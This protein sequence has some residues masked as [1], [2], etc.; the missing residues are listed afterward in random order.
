MMGWFKQLIKKFRQGAEQ[1]AISFVH[2][3]KTA[4]TSF[5]VLLDRFFQAEA[6]FPHQLWR[7]VKQLSPVKN[8]RYELFRGHFGGGG[9]KH[10]TTRPL[11]YLTILRDPVSLACSTYQYV[12]REQN[13]RVHDLLKADEMSLAVFINH[14]ETGPLVTNRLIRNISFDFIDDPAAQEVFLSPQTI[15]YLQQHIKPKPQPL[16]D[17]DRLIRAETFLRQ[18]RWFG[19]VERFDESM[20][21]LCFTMGWRPIGQSQRLNTSRGIELSEQTEQALK[22]LNLEDLRLYQSAKVMFSERHQQMLTQLE[23]LRTGADQTVD[24]LLDVHYQQQPH[25]MASEVDH[26]FDQ[27]VQG[28]QW[29]RREWLDDEQGYFRWTGPGAQANIDFWLQPQDYQLR[30]RIINA[31]STELLDE[32]QLLVN[33]QL[34]NWH[35]EDQGVVR[36][37]TAQCPA[38]WVAPNGLFRLSL[39]V[40]DMI[41]HRDAF[42]SDD[43][44]LVGV[45]VHWIQLSHV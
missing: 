38:K 24:D 4:G 2:I 9:F 15:D 10:L 28:Q 33:D 30:L 21:L 17:G 7:E 14:A 22:A 45:A 12:Q 8:N 3:P 23:K 5:I 25:V 37:L 31:T 20:Q 44:R 43:D 11:E 18:C 39:Q 29:H 41:S 19:L 26:H 13:T 1:P 35:S 27:V 36:V 6:I 42:G 16:A 32:L 40:N 34:L